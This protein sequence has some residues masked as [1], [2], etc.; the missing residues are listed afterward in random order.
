VAELD[1]A[2]TVV[3]RFV[4]GT[5]ANVPDYMVKG[6][7]TYRILSDH[8]GSVRLVVDASTGAVAQRLDYDEFGVVL[9][10]TNPGFQPFGFAGGIYDHQTKLVRFGARDYDAQVGRW[11]S[12]DPVLFAGG[13][14]NLYGYVLNDPM[15]LSDCCGKAVGEE[16]LCLAPGLAPAVLTP[17]GALVA[18]VVLAGAAV[19]ALTKTCWLIGRVMPKT[20]PQGE[21]LPRDNPKPKCLYFCSFAAPGSVGFSYEFGPPNAD[22]TCPKKK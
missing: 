16:C 18:G 19:Y 12:K 21:C 5:K 22:G 9:T 7:V 3:S 20:P 2:G 14:N 6:G 11:T 1:G 10:D 17:V 15:N 4:Y 8:L 13:D